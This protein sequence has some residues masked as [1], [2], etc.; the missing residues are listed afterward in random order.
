MNTFKKIRLQEVSNYASHLVT[1]EGG[2]GGGVFVGVIIDLT[3]NNLQITDHKEK[4]ISITENDS[5]TNKINLNPRYKENN[6][7]ITVIPTAYLIY[8]LMV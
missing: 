8:Y 4:K 6:N 1:V 2:G 3:D 5:I 7:S